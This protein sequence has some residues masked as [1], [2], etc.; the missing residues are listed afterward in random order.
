MRTI[1]GDLLELGAAGRFDVIIHGC[2]CM[3]HMGKGIA[4]SVRHRFPAAHKADQA[5]ENGST[6]KLGNYSCATV[7]CD[8]E[9]TLTI[10][11]AYTQYQF[12]G[13]RADYGAIREA[14]QRI[15]Q[16]FAGKRIGYP[17]IGAGLAGGDWNVISKIIDEELEGEDH[18]LVEFV[19]QGPAK[20]QRNPKS[21]PSGRGRGSGRGGS[22][23][24]GSGRGGS[25]RGG[26]G[27][28]SHSDGAW[29]ESTNQK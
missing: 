26:S 17:L 4:L 28:G 8:A 14:F 25:G 15:K 11:N 10:V 24:G 20:Q 2:N 21:L 6:E 7:G 12:G 18:T 9:H 13:R 19:P 29:S 23:R 5:T 1:P 22:G 3:N 27:R 16:D